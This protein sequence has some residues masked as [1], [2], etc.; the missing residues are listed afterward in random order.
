MRGFASVVVI[1]GPS[2]ELLGIARERN[3]PI[4]VRHFYFGQR[5]RVEYLVGSDDP[6]E[7]EDVGRHRIDLVV[8]QR[9]REASK[10]SLFGCVG[11]WLVSYP[12]LEIIARLGHVIEVEPAELLR[13][14]PCGDVAVM[15]HIGGNRHAR[16]PCLL[17]ERARKAL[18]WTPSA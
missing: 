2:K 4:P 14:Q 18:D 11:N 1:P 3:E 9:L 15:I 6:V 13:V 17:Y 5:L 10:N 7:I 12:V 16:W 8:C